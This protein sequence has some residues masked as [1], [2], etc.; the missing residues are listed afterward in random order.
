MEHLDQRK[1]QTLKFLIDEIGF[2]ETKFFQTLIPKVFPRDETC[3]V[4]TKFWIP[5]LS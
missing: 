4:E 5:P 3:F 1:T 2:L